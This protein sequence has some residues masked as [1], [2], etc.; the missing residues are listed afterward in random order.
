MISSTSE[1]IADCASLMLQDVFMTPGIALPTGVFTLGGS[2]VYYD[3][4]LQTR[5]SHSMQERWSEVQRHVWGWSPLLAEH[6][7]FFIHP[8]PSSIFS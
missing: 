7:S 5:N 4:R 1:D 8:P 2:A 6:F 3:A